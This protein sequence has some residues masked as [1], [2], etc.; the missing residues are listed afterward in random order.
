AF[1]G[2]ILA[3]FILGALVKRVN[4]KNVITGLIL[5]VLTNI[6]LWLLA[7]KVSWL[8]WNPIGFFVAVITAISTGILF[9]TQEDVEKTSWLLD[10]KESNKLKWN[11]LFQDKKILILI[12]MFIFIVGITYTLGFL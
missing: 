8:W 7:P 4:S 10:F 1:Y 12:L 3:V 5:G 2:P 9:R 11:I 6:S